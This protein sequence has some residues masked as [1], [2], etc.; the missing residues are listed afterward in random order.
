MFM[1]H[2]KTQKKERFL[3]KFCFVSIIRVHDANM[4]TMEVSNWQEIKEMVISFLTIV[5]FI[6]LAD[7][8]CQNKLLVWQHSLFLE[9]VPECCQT[10]QHSLTPSNDYYYDDNFI[11]STQINE[12]EIS[13]QYD[14]CNNF[15]WHHS[16][17]MV[18][19][20]F[21]KPLDIMTLGIFPVKKLSFP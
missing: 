6:P 13:G 8:S 12:S 3:L 5:P 19:I 14:D 9:P 18:S 1:K 16:L 20:F 21:V 17:F 2:N 4:N 11:P 10:E 7:L 15:C